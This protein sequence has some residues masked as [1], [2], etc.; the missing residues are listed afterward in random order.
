MNKFVVLSKRLFDLFFGFLGV[1]FLMPVFI[2]I[3]LLIK[4]DSKG[5]IL[6]RQ[7]RL[8]KDLRPFTIYKFRS[9]V[10]G[11]ENMEGGIFN[12]VGDQRVTRIGRFLRDSSLDELPQFINIIKGDM[13]F[14]GPRP[15][16]TYELGDLKKLSKDFKD[17]FRVKP[18]VTGLSQISGRNENTWDKKVKFDNDYIEKFYK[19]GVLIDVKIILLTFIKVV[20]NEGGYETHENIE[21]DKKRMNP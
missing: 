8:G 4:L 2:I 15:P 3:A 17:R 11:A 21:K 7:R 13:S 5:S 6:F 19:Y 1:F 9:M 20:K 12:T 16:V 18:G 10:E 14:V